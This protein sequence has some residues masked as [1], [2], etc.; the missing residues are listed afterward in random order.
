MAHVREQVR[1]A[2]TALVTGLTTTG[3]RVYP[4]RISVMTSGDMPGLRIYTPREFAPI[5]DRE[6]EQRRDLE[7]V[8]DGCV[9]ADDSA[10]DLLD[11]ICSEVETA[12]GAVL[13]VSGKAVEF[14]LAETL[15]ELPSEADAAVAVARMTFIVSF[16]T[17]QGEPDTLL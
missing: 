4:G 12:L 8:I 16:Y 3:S 17:D 5:L 9:E 6:R 10:I 11:T 14:I 15:T 7:L 2:V 13:T 1:D